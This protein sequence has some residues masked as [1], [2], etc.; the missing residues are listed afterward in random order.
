MGTRF[1]YLRK[2]IELPDCDISSRE[3]DTV[4]L[5]RN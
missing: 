2:G 1:P 3:E 5:Q 4:K